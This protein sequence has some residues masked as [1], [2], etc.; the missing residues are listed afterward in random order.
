MN[1]EHE[2]RMDFWTVCGAA[3]LAAFAYWAMRLEVNRCCWC[4][5]LGLL[6]QARQCIVCKERRM[7]APHTH[8]CFD[9]VGVLLNR[10][11]FNI[12]H[13]NSAMHHA[14]ADEL[15]LLGGRLCPS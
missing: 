10:F 14:S 2:L 6:R 12:V 5:M 7:Q 8:T 13:V 1:F 9:H 15:Y 3:L 4:R 11:V